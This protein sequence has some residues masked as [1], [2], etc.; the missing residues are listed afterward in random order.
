MSSFDPRRD[1]GPSRHPE[2]VGI[3]TGI[4]VNQG[5]LNAQ[6]PPPKKSNKEQAGRITRHVTHGRH[7][8]HAKNAASTQQRA[9]CRHRGLFF[10]E[11]G[12]GSPLCMLVHPG[13]LRDSLFPRLVIRQLFLIFRRWAVLS[14]PVLSREL[15]RSRLHSFDGNARWIYTSRQHLLSAPRPACHIPRDVPASQFRRPTT[16]VQCQGSRQRIHR[17]CS[18][19][20]SFLAFTG[21]Q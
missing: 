21:C 14:T 9:A 5:N 16:V 3:C 15:G 10:Q 7:S 17:T 11:L 1:I 2:A 19:S 20:S 12:G 4:A 8:I 18:P 13:N 6:S